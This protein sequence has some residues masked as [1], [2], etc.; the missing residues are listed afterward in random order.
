MGRLM[1]TLAIIFSSTVHV[2][3]QI[4]LDQIDSTNNSM[5]YG[6]VNPNRYKA[7]PGVLIGYRGF[8]NHFLELGMMYAGGR[9]GIT[10]FELTTISNLKK[11]DHLAGVSIGYFSGFAYMEV[12][13]IGTVYSDFQNVTPYLKP[14]FGLGAGGFGTVNYGINIPI[15]RNHFKEQV[16]LHELRL[17]IRWPLSI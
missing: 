4:Q 16:S 1:I 3:A 17:I 13:I 8:R 11:E 6:I 7:H 15:G 14:S 9:H 5:S 10:G 12:G 2:F